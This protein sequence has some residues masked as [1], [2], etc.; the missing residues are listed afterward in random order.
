MSGVPGGPGRG[1]AVQSRSRQT[2]LPGPGWAQHPCGSPPVHTHVQYN[3][4]DLFHVV[5]VCAYTIQFM[6][7]VKKVPIYR[8]YNGTGNIVPFPFNFRA[9][10]VLVCFQTIPV[11]F[12]GQPVRSSEWPGRRN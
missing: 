1:S 5:Y 12:Q 3:T 9:V 7:G 8:P 4:E 2:C 10:A 6:V 11:L